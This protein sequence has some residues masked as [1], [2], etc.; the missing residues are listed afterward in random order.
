MSYR[1][2]SAGGGFSTVGDFLKFAVALTSNKLLDEKHT[3]LLITGKV[4]SERPGSKYAYGFEDD[5]T[6]DGVRRIGHGGGAP[7]MNG[8]LSIYPASGYVVIG[9]SNFD[10]PAAEKLTRFVSVRLPLKKQ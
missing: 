5:V 4:D 9:L 2:T 1:G 7:G 3:Q 6:T 10:P 8:R